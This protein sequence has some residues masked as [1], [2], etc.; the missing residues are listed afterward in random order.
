MHF[1]TL[2]K[3]PSP[4]IPNSL[5]VDK[6]LPEFVATDSAGFGFWNHRLAQLQ[7]LKSCDLRQ[8]LNQNTKEKAEADRTWDVI[9]S[10]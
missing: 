6:N 3:T 4:T 1:N 9:F 7:F 10:H 8:L 5:S 2:Q